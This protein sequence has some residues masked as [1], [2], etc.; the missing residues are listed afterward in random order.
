MDLKMVIF[1]P[2]QFISLVIKMV[3]EFCSAVGQRVPGLEKLLIFIEKNK[4]LL[5]I[6]LITIL[7]VGLFWILRCKDRAIS[8]DSKVWKFKDI[9]GRPDAVTQKG[10]YVIPHEFKSRALNGSTPLLGNVHQLLAYCYLLEKHGY[11]VKYGILEYADSKWVIRWNKKE[12][13]KF[14]KM[15]DTIRE[16]LVSK[17]PPQRLEKFD[18]RCAKCPYRYKC[19]GKN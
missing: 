13:R 3:E 11:K 19:W 12:Y 1:E 17:T 5:P 9:S 7:G 2:R 4:A 6:G 14:L 16:T 8:I 18:G 10:S 15:V